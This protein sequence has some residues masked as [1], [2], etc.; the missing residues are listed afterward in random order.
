MLYELLKDFVAGRIK[1]AE[2]LITFYNYIVTG[3]GKA[4]SIGTERADE[5]DLTDC[6][7]GVE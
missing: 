4:L 1:R 7:S 6:E 5:N 3:C 2:R